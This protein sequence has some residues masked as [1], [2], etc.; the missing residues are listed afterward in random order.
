VQ[1]FGLEEDN[2]VHLHRSWTILFGVYLFWFTDKAINIY[3]ALKKVCQYTDRFVSPTCVYTVQARAERTPP[4][5]QK[6]DD[7]AAKMNGK[8]ESDDSDDENE[9]LLF[10]SFALVH[11][12]ARTGLDRERSGTAASTR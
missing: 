2:I 6:N 12:H 4:V 3:R 5:K 10:A 8:H 7:E 9:V 1:A 11:T